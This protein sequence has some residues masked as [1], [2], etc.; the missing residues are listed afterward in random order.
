MKQKAE[1]SNFK[2][3]DIENGMELIDTRFNVV[4]TVCGKTS[5]SVEIQHKKL[6]PNGID[7]KNWYELSW[8]NK[9]F[10]KK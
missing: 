2:I 6:K 1:E 9:L 4:V 3:E 7:C 8:V 5:S 10:K